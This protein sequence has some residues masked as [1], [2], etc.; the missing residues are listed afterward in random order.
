MDEKRERKQDAKRNHD[1]HTITR[2][3]ELPSGAIKRGF[4][5]D[6]ETS[7]L[8][9]VVHGTP[10]DMGARTGAARL[11]N[12]PVAPLGFDIGRGLHA[13][14]PIARSDAVYPLKTNDGARPKAGR[15]LL[16]EA[17]A[18]VAI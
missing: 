6:G 18:S 1:P 17:L 2:S 5:V 13:W 15:L 7:A 12:E 4:G 8:T 16:D 14:R 3:G 11:S 10:F 9:Y